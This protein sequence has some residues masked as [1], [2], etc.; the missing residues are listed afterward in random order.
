[1][2][3]AARQ[4]KNQLVD[5]SGRNRLLN[6]RD[7][8]V[9]TMDLTPGSGLRISPRRLD[10]L[11]AGGTTKLSLLVPDEESL[12]DARKRLGAIYRRTQEHL[13]EKGINTLFAA[14]G[15][16]TWTVE[17]GTR[18]NAP[19]ILI[20]VTASPLDAARWDFTVE[21]SGDPHLNPVLAHVFRTEFGMDMSDVDDRL[22]DGSPGSL[23]EL[24]DVLTQLAAQWTQV[25]GIHLDPRVV[26]GNFL[27]TN[28]PMVAD[29]DNNV[30]AF[31]GNDLVASIAGVEEA[32]RALADQIVDPSPNQPD[33][34]P[35][36]SEFLV[37][38]ADASQ[39]RAI[40][41]VLGGSIRG[42]LGDRRGPASPRP[43]PI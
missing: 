32:R 24:T 41:R 21:L 17:S 28:M 1:M 14:A 39:H 40:N 13:D 7:L 26:L 42:D 31:A 9:G 37:L 2:R 33:L 29:L 16:A 35:P 36:E 20:P 18:P 22:A 27:Y 43:L 12:V 25:R 30:E 6:Y 4:W 5:V 19:V 11:I 34:D 10:S 3:R 15:L 38:D 8:K 23:S